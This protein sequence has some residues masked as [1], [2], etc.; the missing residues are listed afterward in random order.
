[1]AWFSRISRF[2]DVHM[3]YGQE[4][5]MSCGIASVLMCVF[6]INKFTPGAAAVH[7][8]TKVCDLYA[9]ASGGVYKPETVGTHPTHLVTVLNGLNCGSWA[10]AGL[11]GAAASKKI[12]DTVGISGG[13]GPT[14]TV[15]PVIVG[16]DWNAGGAHWIVIDTI[17]KPFGSRYATICDP[18]DTNLHVQEI[19]DKSPFT[20]DAGQGGL[21][22]DFWGSHKGQ[23]S[24]YGKTDQG[25]LKTWGIIYRK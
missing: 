24:P 11:A 4:A 1:M 25:V 2:G 9:T 23:T 7:E 14:A 8:E 12:L 17:R 16:V 5:G 20:Y 10:W 18:W 15:N 13:I 21:S 22:V 19:S 6:K 3:V